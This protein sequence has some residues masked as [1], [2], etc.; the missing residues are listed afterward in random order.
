LIF[1]ESYDLAFPSLQMGCL[2]SGGIPPSFTIVR[3]STEQV[4]IEGEAAIRY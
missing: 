1:S 2:R 3:N 4:V